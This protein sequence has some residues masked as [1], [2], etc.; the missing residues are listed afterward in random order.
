MLGSQPYSVSSARGVCALTG[1]AFKSGE[2]CVSVLVEHEDDRLERL[3]IA[4]EAWDAGDRP[5]R[6]HRVVGIWRTVI[7]DKERPRQ[8]LVGDDEVLDLF[9]QLGEAT[10]PKQLVFRSLLCL[11]LIRR[12]LLTWE[13]ATPPAGGR[14]GVIR[15]RRRG[16]KDA[17]PSEVIDPGL[18]DES[19]ESAFQQLSVVMNL[20]TSDS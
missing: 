7:P 11:I 3:D 2:P 4:A 10:D 19:I 1:R 5:P 12:R 20:E 16:E 18:D 8:Q 13:G 17:P 15:V 9:D 14:P 6:S